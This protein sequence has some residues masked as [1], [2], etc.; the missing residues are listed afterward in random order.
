[1]NETLGQIRQYPCWA[2][3][4]RAALKLFYMVP[5]VTV[6]CSVVF[7]Y[8]FLVEVLHFVIFL[9]LLSTTVHVPLRFLSWFCVTVFRM[10]W[11]KRAL[12]T[13]T[14][15]WG[16][17]ASIRTSC[18]WKK[19]SW[20][21][22]QPTLIQGFANQD[23]LVDIARQIFFFCLVYKDCVQIRAVTVRW[24]KCGKVFTCT[25]DGSSHCIVPR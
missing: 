10:F 5:R 13:R 11:L 17:R 2:N 7:L 9:S 3:S 22:L 18:G 25:R 16:A 24:L 19:P 4:A 12:W 14:T 23:A 21:N 20:E 1:M 8:K 6:V 15:C